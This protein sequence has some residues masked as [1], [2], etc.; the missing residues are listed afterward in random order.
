[1]SDAEV[2]ALI[3]A[4]LTQ[5]APNRTEEWS[6]VALHQSIEALSLDSIATMEMVGFL[7]DKTSATFPDEELAK[8]NKLA[9]LA[10]LIRTGHV[11]A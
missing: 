6:K 9:D 5:V 3:Q 7:E 10:S 4:A 8:V 1:M 11:A 2:L